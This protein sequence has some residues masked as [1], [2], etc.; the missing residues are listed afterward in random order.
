[1][2]E[3]GTRLYEGQGVA[4]S[5]RAANKALDPI[6]NIKTASRKLALEEDIAIRKAIAV[7]AAKT[8]DMSRKIAAMKAGGFTPEQIA[9]AIAG[10]KPETLGEA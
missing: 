7:G 8:T 6:Q 9:D 1:M 2:V 10:I 5:L 4:E 3:G